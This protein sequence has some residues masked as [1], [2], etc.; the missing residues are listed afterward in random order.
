MSKERKRR[1]GLS[2]CL[3]KIRQQIIMKKKDL[4]LVVKIHK[5]TRRII[6]NRLKILDIIKQIILNQSKIS[7]QAIKMKFKMKKLRR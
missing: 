6:K 3:I 1:I 2:L 7:N 4:M 5:Q